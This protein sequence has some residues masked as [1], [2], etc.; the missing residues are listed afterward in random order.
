[1]DNPSTY[2]TI[3]PTPEPRALA[4]IPC[5]RPQ[6]TKSHTIRKYA[7]MFLS[8]RILSSRSRRA[9]FG[10]SAPPPPALPGLTP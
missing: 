4:G 8:A 10:S 5:C 7:E 9:V 3:V 6:F 1:M 2:P